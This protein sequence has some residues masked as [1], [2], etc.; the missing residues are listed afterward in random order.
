MPPWPW[1]LREKLDR[2]LTLRMEETAV[3]QILDWR[4]DVQS[5]G[6]RSSGVTE[7]DS[8]NQHTLGTHPVLQAQEARQASS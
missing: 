3:A 4:G 5:P 2:F 1:D 7:I 8:Y 6:E